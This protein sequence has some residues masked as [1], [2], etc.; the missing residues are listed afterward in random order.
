MTHSQKEEL[1]SQEL[2]QIQGGGL[3]IK[4]RLTSPINGQ[5]MGVRKMGKRAMDQNYSN[6]RASA[7]MGERFFEGTQR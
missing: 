5:G 1:S 2:D 3:P 7:R 6:I 4:Q